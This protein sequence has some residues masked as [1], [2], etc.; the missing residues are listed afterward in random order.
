MYVCVFVDVYDVHVYVCVC[1][2]M[3]MCGW[4]RKREGSGGACVSYY[5]IRH[6]TQL[7]TA[8]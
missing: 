1:R 3:Y 8:L 7:V 4:E 6:C 5:T 2:C